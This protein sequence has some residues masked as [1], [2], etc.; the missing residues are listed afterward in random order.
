MF[1]SFSKRIDEELDGVR[2]SEV[3]EGG[4]ERSTEITLED[5][6]ELRQVGGFGGSYHHPCWILPGTHVVRGGGV[7][8]QA[9]RTTSSQP[10]SISLQY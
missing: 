10:D 6:G 7:G 8:V 1:C 2:H 4:R 9:D 5:P 3:E